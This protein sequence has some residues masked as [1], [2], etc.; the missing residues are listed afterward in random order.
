MRRL[1][2]YTGKGGVGKSV[3][4]AA[5]ALKLSDLGYTV[6]LIS[7]DPAHTISAYFDIPLSKDTAKVNERVDL[8]YIDPVLEVMKKFKNMSEY[9]LEW[10]RKYGIDEV[11]AYEL[12]ML[13]MVTESMGLL[14]ALE[15]Y[16]SGKYNM[17]IID[18]IP[19]AE[20][21]RLLYLPTILNS[22]RSRMIKVSMSI[23]RTTAKMLSVILAPASKLGKV[24]EEEE[25]FF[26]ET[27]KLSNLITNPDITSVR[28]IAN[29]DTSSVDDAI[30]SVGL[31]QVFNLN[32]DLGIMNKISPIEE[33][34]KQQ[35]EYVRR[36]EM[37]IYPI[38]VRKIKQ[39]GIEVK[40]CDALRRLAEE[41]YGE[42]DPSKVYYVGKIVNVREVEEGKYVLEMMMPP[43][44]QDCGNVYFQGDELVIEVITDRGIVEKIY[45]LPT[46][47]KLTQ[48]VKAYV[49]DRKLI[50]E[51][52]KT[53]QQL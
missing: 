49:K 43:G 40:G 51:F 13:P 12:A 16:E 32:V 44:V 38:P 20:A 28:V 45:P 50:I 17:I 47:L 7:T 19:S 5:T 3:I 39:K 42:D 22:I 24:V 2:V 52:V 15:L 21:L 6:A 11:L 25:M 23:M 8:Y 36:F 9:F 34:A 35:E 4:S 29:P 18:T 48:P 1:L 10:L 41:L 14:K 26:N 33:W 37:S 27:T 46:M 53:S 31:A 30:K